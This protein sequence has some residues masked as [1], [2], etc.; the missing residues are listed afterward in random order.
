VARQALEKANE[1]RPDHV[2]TLTALGNAYRLAG[3]HPRAIQTFH[4]VT[5]LEPQDARGFFHLAQ[6]CNAAGDKDGETSALD[7]VLALDPNFQPGIAI[8]HGLEPGRVNAEI[9]Q[10]L[11][12]FAE[13]NNSWMAWL[14]AS[15]V[16]RDRGDLAAAQQRVE[17]AYAIKPEAEDVLLQ[18]SSILGDT[19]DAARL[20]DAIEPAVRLG[21]YSKRLDWNYAQALRQ[22]DRT[23]EAIALL[24]DAA[25]AP[26]AQADFKQAASITIDFWNGLLAEGGLRAEAH[27]AGALRRPLLL[28]LDDGDGG[29]ILPGGKPLPAEHRFPFRTNGTGETEARVRIQ[30][31]QSGGDPAPRALGT[32]IVSGIRPAGVG[33]TTIECFAGT[34][35][36]GAL[37]FGAIQDGRRLQVAWSAPA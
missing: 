18:Y 5:E 34:T 11:T 20:A 36:E 13:A 17:R 2:R 4:R 21:K 19:R 7:R 25:A 12:A 23:G 22:L 30:Q 24:R 10:R 26:D 3:E 8:R 35:N 9:E 16:A 37:R 15:S 29:V 28:A 6:A 32:F 33:P 1:L 31:G 14:I 27:R